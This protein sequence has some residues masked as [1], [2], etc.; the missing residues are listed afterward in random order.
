MILNRIFKS[1]NWLLV[2]PALLLTGIGLLSIYSSSVMSGYFFDFK[3]QIAYFLVSVLLMVALSFM[4]LRFLKSNSYLI[5]MFYVFSL[6]SLMG[7]ILFTGT[8]RGIR[9]WYKIGPISLD[10]VPLSAIILII[11]LAKYFST[12]HTELKTFKPIVFSAVYA[13]IPGFLVFLQPDL[14]SAL[15]LFAIW[16]G[17][18]VFSGI[19][20][21]HFL[22]L[23]LILLMLL[24]LSWQFVLKD[25]QKQRIMSFTNPQ[26][27]QQGVSWSVNQSK[28]AIGSGGVLGSGF[29]HGTQTQYGFLSE[30]KTD[31]IFSAIAE[32][33]GLLASLIVLS[34]LLFLFLMILRVA[35]RSNNNFTRLFA[36]GFAFL[37]LSQSFINLGMCLGL[38]PVVGLPL[39][40]VS[41][42]G[43]Q[44][45][46]FYVGLGILISLEKRT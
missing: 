39:P 1:F 43:S 36:T 37:I 27:D 18:L 6:L 29:A 13:V 20:L 11:V 41:Y 40:F 46:A 34:L 21:K 26:I 15:T 19:K 4:D 9:G 23:C 32:E 2:S 33:G 31:F 30:P 8:T 10:P 12:R 17:I 5:L 3:K 25:Y 35:F 22:L 45:L 14:G 24:G 42:G 44:L 16:F 38:F 28:I 7:L